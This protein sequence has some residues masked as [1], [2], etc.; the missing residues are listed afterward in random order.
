MQLAASGLF[1]VQANQTH[2]VAK[3]EPNAVSKK[4]GIAASPEEVASRV[5]Q[6]SPSCA[7]Q[8]VNQLGS[9]A[10]K[11]KTVV[12]NMV[13][14]QCSVNKLILNINNKHIKK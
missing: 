1:P 12:S 4:T 13:A 9:V 10:A 5:P 2:F 6:T 11:P 14:L 8:G 7:L 3:M